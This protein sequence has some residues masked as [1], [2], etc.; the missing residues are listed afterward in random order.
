MQDIIRLLPDAIANQIAAGEV[1]QRP[2]SIVKE[3]LENA[4][5][6]Q[7]KTIRLLVKDAGKTLVQVIDDG[8]GMSE[9][10]ARMSFERHA[11]SKIKTT[12]DLF[13]I[14]T[15]GFRGEAL[16]SIAAVAQVELKTRRVGDD[17][18]TC[19]QIEGSKIKS[20][21]TIAC[22]LGTSLA[23][24]NVFFNV[25]AR[26]N[27]L[28]SNPVEMR[29]ILDEFQRVVLAH[30]EI[31]FSLYHNDLEVYQ[32]PA[33][34]LSQRIVQIFGK[35]Y[36]KQ[37]ASCQEDTPLLNIWG[38]IG[39]PENAKKTRGE[40]FFLVNKRYIRH[41]Y[42]HHAVVSAYESL[43][44][45]DNHPFYVLFLEID[46]I[47]IDINIHPTKTEVKFDDERTVYAIVQSA[48]RK[49]LSVHNLTPAID[50]DVDV[51]FNPNQLKTNT[52]A[53]NKLYPGDQSFN[54][55]PSQEFDYRQKNNLD[56]WEK[57]YADL[58][59]KTPES[60]PESE[61]L[62]T[63]ESN[64]NQI[65]P[66]KAKTNEGF[67][68]KNRSIIQVQSQYLLTPVK[69]GLMM[70]D[71]RAA[72]ERIWYDKLV[73]Q[74]DKMAGLSQQLV[75]PAT[76]QLNSTDFQLISEISTEI[77]NL[78][79]VFDV[80]SENRLLLKGIPADC[81]GEN[82]QELLEGLLEQFKN[83]QAELKVDKNLRLKRA[84]AKR[85][86]HKSAKL[87]NQAEMNALIDRL[88]ASS[89]PHYTPSGNL[90]IVMLNINQITNFFTKTHLWDNNSHQ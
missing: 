78:G 56:N 54:F 4:I 67:S 13:N 25:P 88:F 31:E 64:V 33:T 23:V 15:M 60:E 72:W 45:A 27:F 21:E 71:Q 66:E 49:A 40:Q 8:I 29:H 74:S 42:L 35:N 44:P 19:I 85:H 20:Q 62:L 48:V 38:Y 1:V 82:E 84:L 58:K 89:N 79:F 61:N 43:I 26:R 34:K 24:K 65:S 87:M 86:A 55:K 46:P 53:E 68:P 50:F 12:D 52:L 37:L 3:L 80:L 51:N 59:A 69:S 47:H 11:T 36:Q 32:L 70:I 17:L 81:E 22:Q 30:P 28:K 5:D 7:A 57:I 39:K 76:I 83:L 2:A 18:G 63:F 41:S 90:I 6:A 14:R 77:H 73:N 9:T 10:D 16:A 75:F